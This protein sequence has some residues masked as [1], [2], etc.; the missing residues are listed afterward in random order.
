MFR[1]HTF[2]ILFFSAVLLNVAGGVNQALGLHAGMYFWLLTSGQLQ[3]LALAAVSGLVLGAP[4]IGPFLVRFEKRT[5]MIMAELSGLAINQE[6]S[7]T[8]APDGF[9]AA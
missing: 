3:G 2:R 9:A 7:N 1:K 4:L 5:L 8:S 6:H